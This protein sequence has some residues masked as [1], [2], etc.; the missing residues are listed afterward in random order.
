MAVTADMAKPVR[1]TQSGRSNPTAWTQ[2][3]RARENVPAA[4]V[5]MDRPEFLLS[6]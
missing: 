2:A 1:M 5:A 4:S 6:Y 3:L